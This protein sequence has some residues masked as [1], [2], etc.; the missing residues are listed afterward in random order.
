MSELTFSIW[1]NQELIA[2]RCSLVTL[3]EQLDKLVYIDGPQL[4]QLYMEQ[5][6]NYEESV[7]RAEIECE[8]L[9]KKQ[10]IIQT[11]IN[12]HKPIDLSAIDQ[13]IDILRRQMLL[14]AAGPASAQSYDRLSEEEREDLQ[15][16]YHRIVRSFHPETHP[17]LTDTHR[18]L[19]QKA[20]EAYRRRDLPA[21]R[22]I[23]QMLVDADGI[24]LDDLL[25][26]L[27]PEEAP[28]V[29]RTS[30]KGHSTDFTLAGLLYPYIKPSAEETAV[31]ESIRA[32]RNRADDILKEMDLIRTQFPHSAAEMLGDPEKVEAYKKDLE[33]R[34]QNA[35]QEQERRTQEINAMIEREAHHE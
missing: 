18:H 26:M 3:H 10:Q 19:F 33:R 16:L 30:L 25:A 12:R 27:S 2:A 7:I 8:L 6:G 35:V 34:M 4:E 31:Q 23:Y 32:F 20:Q 28:T 21:L 1:L 15:D 9:R 5:V 22:L 17:E 29:E 14:A 24:S 13:E 11:A